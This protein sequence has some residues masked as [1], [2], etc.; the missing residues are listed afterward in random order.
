MAQPV[1][2]ALQYLGAMTIKANTTYTSAT[3]LAT[4][5]TANLMQMKTSGVSTSVNNSDMFLTS[6]DDTS[7]F[8][9]GTTYRFD[10]DC[11]VALCKATVVV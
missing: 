10:K 5:P 4:Y 1:A 7:L 9:T 8:I 11:V 6:F 3:I 2:Y